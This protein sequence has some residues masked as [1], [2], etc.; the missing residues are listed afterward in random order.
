MMKLT[1]PLVL[2]GALLLFG[3]VPLSQAQRTKPAPAPASA[4]SPVA[5]TAVLKAGTLVVLETT[6]PISSQNAQIGQSV[7][8]RVKYDVKA[9]GQT[10]I[11][12]GSPAT[13]QVSDAMHRKGMGK[14]GFVN[15]RAT[16]MQAVDGQMVPLTGGNAVHLG[17]EHAG[18][19]HCPSGRRNPALPAQEG[20]R[21]RAAGRLRDAGH[22]GLRN[23]L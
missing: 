19:F 17:R 4:A 3:A 22:R 6:N 23:N 1:S 10:V 16:A 12:A 11:K 2:S 15:I 18:H 13:G 5:A 21:S 8:L 20:E 9:D 7:P 14:Q